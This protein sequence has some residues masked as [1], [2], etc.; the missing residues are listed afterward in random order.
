[1]GL[2]LSPG[3]Y[4]D[5]RELIDLLYF[6]NL[7]SGGYLPSQGYGLRTQDYRR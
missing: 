2:G 3:Y 5:L 7:Y 1:M 6:S 4:W